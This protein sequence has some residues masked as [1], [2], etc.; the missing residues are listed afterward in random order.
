MRYQFI[1]VHREEYPISILCETLEVPV[2]GY[3]AWRKRPMSQH[4]REDCQLAERIQE[5]YRG[6]RQ[7]YGSPRIHA[8]LQA[9]GM[10]SSRKRVARLMRERGL[11]ADWM[12]HG[13]DPGRNTH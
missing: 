6:S 7:V 13:G 10:I 12:G 2:S 8:E 9:C 11:S 5:A 4:A 1:E 3:Y